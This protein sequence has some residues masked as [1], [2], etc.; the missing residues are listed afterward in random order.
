MANFR[1][2]INKLLEHGKVSASFSKI[3]SFMKIKD[4]LEASEDKVERNRQKA[5]RMMDTAGDL[6]KAADE[7]LGKDSPSP[8]EL[9]QARKYAS[10][11]AHYFSKAFATY[12]EAEPYYLEGYST[13]KIC[14]ARASIMLGKR[15][16]AHY[17]LSALIGRLMNAL[18]SGNPEERA[19][20]PIYKALAHALEL[21]GEVEFNFIMTGGGWFIDGG[22]APHLDFGKAEKIYREVL[23][24]LENADRMAERHD[25]VGQRVFRG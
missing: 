9:R 2:K 17:D 6:A 12:P 21:R 3:K 1:Y 25:E 18:D 24:D 14:E 13:A 22:L 8:E 20:A 16:S 7:I 11:A 4:R 15:T 19:I 23:G 10:D 5:R